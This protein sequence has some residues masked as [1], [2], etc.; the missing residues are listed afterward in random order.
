[1]LSNNTRG[2]SLKYQ[3]VPKRRVQLL[4][5]TRERFPLSE[6]ARDQSKLS[7][8]TGEQFRRQ[9]CTKIVTTNTLSMIA[10]KHW[11]VL[12]TIDTQNSSANCQVAEKK[13]Y[14]L[15][16]LSTCNL[17]LWCNML[18]TFYE[19]DISLFCHYIFKVLSSILTQLRL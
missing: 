11:R 9:Q 3:K 15:I 12:G 18:T 10:C 14:Y 5:S 19:P 4:E 2:Y 7:K 13:G 17:Y 6:S 1:M 8:N 16:S